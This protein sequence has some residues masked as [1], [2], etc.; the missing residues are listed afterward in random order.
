[1][2]TPTPPYPN[3]PVALALVEVKHPESGPLSQP[4]IVALKA[5]LRPYFPIHKTEEMTEVMLT[6]GPGM[7]PGEHRQSSVPRFISRD[8]QSSVTFRVDAVVVE[9]TR[10]PGWTEFKKLVEACLN[11]REDVAPVD[12]V[13][14]IGIRLIDEIRVPSE[15]SPNWSEWVDQS[16]TGPRI[17]V[18]DLEMHVQ[19]QQSVVQYGSS[20]PGE[21]LT[22]RYGAIQGPPAVQSTPNL[23][24]LNVPDVGP[25]FLL[26]TDAAWTVTDEVAV[27]AFDQS[28]ILNVADR[29]HRP[30]KGLFERSITAQ[31]RTKVLLNAN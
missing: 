8:R 25:Y 21:T 11:A 5:A 26:D 23:V 27:P 19:Q 29:L 4:A 9:T 12:G 2:T 16:L 24:R 28:A 10:Y 30:M 6:F 31:L 7:G 14:R 17:K 13:E 22:L 3:Q 20:A 1:M 15:P 18:D